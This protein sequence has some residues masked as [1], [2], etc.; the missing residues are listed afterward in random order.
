M[1]GKDA[2]AS[3]TLGIGFKHIEPRDYFPHAFGHVACAQLLSGLGLGFDLLNTRFD[4]PEQIPSELFE[5]CRVPRAST[6]AIGWLIHSAV[7]QM[8]RDQ[9]FLN[10]GV[11]HGFT[12]LAGL[13]A[14]RDKTCIGVDAFCVHRKL[15]A[16]GRQRYRGLPRLLHRAGDALTRR[17]FL[18]RFERYAGPDHRF[19]EM[20]YVDYFRRVHREPIGVYIYD[21]Q[22]RYPDQF[23]GL[24]LAEPFFAPG[25]V[26]FI[27]DTNAEDNRRATLDFIAQS[28]Y[29]YETILDVKTASDRHPTFWNGLLAF[30]RV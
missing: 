19:F 10:V 15:D 11:W 3:T 8:P 23:R 22:H 18:R 26:V 2:C 7:R 1:V 27:D 30:R 13:V 29:R 25:C 12:L 14:N 9:V 21:A 24:E 5:L 6:V 20:D 17:A 28:P 16:R 4:H